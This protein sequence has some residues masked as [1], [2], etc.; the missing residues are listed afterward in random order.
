MLPLHHEGIYFKNTTKNIE[1]ILAGL[2]PASPAFTSVLP[3]KLQTYMV[4]S[5]VIPIN[6]RVIYNYASVLPIKLLLMFYQQ[7]PNLRTELQ[8]NT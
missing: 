6:I 7:P 3:I 8:A 4:G 2:E 5:D 1:K